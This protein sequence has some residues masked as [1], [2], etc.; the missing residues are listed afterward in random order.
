MSI[1]QHSDLSN[2]E[3]ILGNFYCISGIDAAGGRDAVQPAQ[4]G[5]SRAAA[6]CDP[7]QCVSGLDDISDILRVLPDAAVCSVI[8]VCV[9]CRFNLFPAGF[10]LK[11]SAVQSLYA[12]RRTP[13]FMSRQ[14]SR[15]QRFHTVYA[16]D[17]RW[18]GKHIAKNAGNN[19]NY[20]DKT[21]I[22]QSALKEWRFTYESLSIVWN[23]E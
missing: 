9:P 2:L 12:H 11:F 22:R 7:A 19:Y 16:E 17:Q 6:L 8:S 23:N 1:C 4:S 13:S 10:S 3:Q 15:T 14:Y 21:A 20:S 18:C 5:Y